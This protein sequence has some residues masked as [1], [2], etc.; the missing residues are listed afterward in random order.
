MLKV[1]PISGPLANAWDHYRNELKASRNKANSKNIHA[2]RV[3]TQRLEAIV[4]IS[5]GLVSNK[6]GEKLIESLKNT[7]KQ[8]GPLRDLQVESDA[9]SSKIKSFSTFVIKEKKKAKQKACRYLEHI[10]LKKEKNLVN[11]IL[12]K[13][14][15]S[16]EK[17]QSVKKMHTL[18]E[19]TVQSTLVR[20]NEALAETTPKK[21]KNLHKFR[22]LAKQLR[23]QEEA[24]KSVFGSTHFNLPKLKAVQMAVGKI[25][26]SNALL[27]NMDRYLDHKKH[28]R[29][30]KTLKAK[31]KI[32]KIQKERIQRVQK[33][34]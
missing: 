32:K 23:Y 25:Q 14:L 34:E 10:S 19:P 17:N 29:D 20:F 33:S 4:K 15:I 18:L 31:K 13:K 6:Y 30:K 24:L 8:L 1:H 11:K 28:R 22:I 21:M 7:R 16:A 9:N 3:A 26:D 27:Q 2:L 5:R 12:S